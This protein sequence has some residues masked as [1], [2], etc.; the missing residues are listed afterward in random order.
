[1]CGVGGFLTVYIDACP[2]ESVVEQGLIQRILVD[3]SPAG[4]VD[5]ARRR[6]HETD[7]SLVNQVMGLVVEVKVEREVVALRNDTVRVGRRADEVG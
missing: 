7:Q 6:L 3:E 1:M 2:A 5:Q 4:D